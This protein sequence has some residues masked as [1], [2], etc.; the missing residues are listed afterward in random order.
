MKKIKTFKE[1]LAYSN[2]NSLRIYEFFQ[3]QEALIQETD[4]KKIRERFQ[5]NLQA[6]YWSVKHGIENQEVS[7]SGLSGLDS[8]RIKN[9]YFNNKNVPFG[10]LYGK[11]MSYALAIMEE[12]LRMGKIVACPT[13]GSCG[14]VPAVIIAYAEKFQFCNARQL[15]ALITAGGIGKVVSHKLALAGAV[16]GCQAECGVASAMAAAAVVELMSGTNEQIFEAVSLALKNTLGLVC[17]PVAGL[18]E[19]P[20]VKRNAFLAIHG[21]T[22]AEIAL[23]G[24]KSA[25]PTDEIVDA[26]KQIGLLMSPLLKECSEAGLATTETGLAIAKKLGL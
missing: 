7:L 13:A 19:I 21:I 20:C 2:E 5:E 4:I 18:V 11:I 8:N 26:M 24:V 23:S 3:Q 15:D 17:D 14:I 22:A 10:D 6:M 16:A 25:I 12:N 1:I 9:R